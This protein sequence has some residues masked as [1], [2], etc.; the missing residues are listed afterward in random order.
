MSDVGGSKQKKSVVSYHLTILNY[1][2]GHHRLSCR[3]YQGNINSQITNDLFSASLP[4]VSDRFYGAT[5]QSFFTQ[6]PLFFSCRLLEHKRI[7]VLVGTDEVLGRGVAA[8]VT[9]DT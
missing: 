8:H 4:I 5:S 6:L 3:W 9:V 7:A 2:F 1:Q